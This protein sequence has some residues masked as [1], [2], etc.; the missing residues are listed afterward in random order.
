MLH[1]ELAVNARAAVRDI[2][3][4]IDNV[5]VREPID[6]ALFW[7]YAAGAFDDDAS[8]RAFDAACASLIQQVASGTIHGRQLHDGLAGAGWV[9]S[10][11]SEG[12]LAGLAALDDLLA[13]E[14]ASAAP[15]GGEVDLVGGL[16]GYAVYFLERLAVG[17]PS[18]ADALA[19]IVAHL[20]ATAERTGAGTTWLTPVSRMPPSRA[21]EA[22]AG[23][24]DCGVAHGVPGI[25]SVLARIAVAD[26]VSSATAASARELAIAGLGWIAAHVLPLHPRGRLRPWV[27][28][29]GASSPGPAGSAWC[30]GE[31]GVALAAW[32]AAA[33]LGEPVDLWRELA[34]TSAAR[35]IEASDVLTPGVCHGA[36]GL[37]HLYNRAYQHS[38]ETVFADATARWIAR[39]LAMRVPGSG[40]GGFTI[41]DGAAPATASQIFLFGVTGIGLGLLAALG[42]VEPGWDRLLACDLPLAGD[43]S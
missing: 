7:A 10:H 1:G 8:S 27:L 22:P 33:R 19:R 25:V 31:P 35:S 39:T 16:A 29:A 36:A 30:Y 12:E 17:A 4:Q 40:P 18:A 13:S 20:A 21:A 9:L 2:A 15:C 28:P 24:Y 6:V 5:L 14:I 23:R 43:P 38:G 37:A 3:A 41:G 26:G 11:V 32:T 42:E 34:R